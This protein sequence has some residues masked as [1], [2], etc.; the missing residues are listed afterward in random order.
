MSDRQWFKRTCTSAVFMLMAGP[1]LADS[2]SLQ[3]SDESFGVGHNI[4]RLGENSSAA[5]DWLHDDDSDLY[6]AGFYVD[7][8]VNDIESSLGAVETKIGMKAFVINTDF[9]N[10]AYGPKVE[11]S[12]RD[13]DINYGF[14]EP[15]YILHSKLQNITDIIQI[16][17]IE[18]YLND[19]NQ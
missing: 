19:E 13:V 10:F 15:T 16:N 17:H 12:F 3:V 7:G 6:R 5:I 1:I 2:I 8:I 18:Q 4:E 14:F 9:L 11:Q